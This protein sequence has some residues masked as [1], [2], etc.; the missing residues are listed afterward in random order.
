MLYKFENSVPKLCQH[1]FLEHC[2]LV[3]IVR[4]QT[5]FCLA[6][7]HFVIFGEQ[8]SNSL[9]YSSCKRSFLVL[10]YRVTTTAEQGAY[11]GSVCRVGNC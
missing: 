1:Y 2:A 7:T 5:S 9:Y 11:K 10:E 4:H 8:S 3:I 6:A